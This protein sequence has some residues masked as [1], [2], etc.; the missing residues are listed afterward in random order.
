MGSQLSDH[1]YRSVDDSCSNLCLHWI[2]KN[3]DDYIEKRLS[4]H[5]KKNYFYFCQ[6]RITMRNFAHS[7]F[8]F[9]LY[10]HVSVNKEMLLGMDCA[11][12]LVMPEDEV[13]IAA[14][15]DHLFRCFSLFVLGNPVRVCAMGTLD[16]KGNGSRLSDWLLYLWPN[17]PP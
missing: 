3:K 14:I 1:L 8:N 12:V 6:S 7:L 2:Q 9:S 5:R 15:S 17:T 11:A 4:G 16:L 13:L 10:L